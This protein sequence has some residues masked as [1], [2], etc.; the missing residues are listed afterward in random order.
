MHIHSLQMV[1]TPKA[2]L[3]ELYCA[4]RPEARQY[5]LNFDKLPSLLPL[6]PH[7]KTLRIR[8]LVASHKEKKNQNNQTSTP[9]TLKSV[10]SQVCFSFRTGARQRR[11]W[12]SNDPS[13][14][15]VVCTLLQDQH[16]HYRNWL[17]LSRTTEQNDSTMATLFNTITLLERTTVLPILDRE[18]T[19][20]YWQSVISQRRLYGYITPYTEQI[21]RER[22]P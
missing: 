19:S 12:K 21:C 14:H 8:L 9:E 4:S 13:G 11:R 6:S 10:T 15:G 22:C 16:P 20:I 2:N 17:L 1:S 18:Q 7:N 3:K 5:L